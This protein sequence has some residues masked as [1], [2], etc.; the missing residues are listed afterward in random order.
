MTE[1][2][3]KETMDL[4]NQKMALP[5]DL[6]SKLKRTSDGLVHIL[7][8]RPTVVTV[9]LKKEPETVELMMQAGTTWGIRFSQPQQFVM[10]KYIKKLKNKDRFVE[11]GT[12]RGQ[13]VYLVKDY[14]KEIV[15]IEIDKTWY[16]KAKKL[17]EDHQHIKL[18]YGDSGKLI[19]EEADLYWLDAHTPV[20]PESKCPLMEELK[21]IEKFEYIL[22]DD[23]VNMNGIGGYPT[24]DRIKTFVENKWGIQCQ[25]E[26]GIIIVDRRNKWT[27][28]T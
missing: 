28:N 14:F 9:F 7:L 6:H 16:E 26:N 19:P 27:S 25:I 5:K 24:F 1:E 11:T 8:E 13:M 17:F 10:S 12:C 20:G 22:I 15:S 21:R 18:L 4:L 23:A 2:K 3:L